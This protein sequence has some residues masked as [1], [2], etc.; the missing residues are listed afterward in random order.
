ML[1]ID[2][3][4]ERKSELEDI[5][6]DIDEQYT[7]DEQADAQEEL[8]EI[9]NFESELGISLTIASQNGVTFIAEHDFTEYAEELASDI[10]AVGVNSYEWP[11]NHIDWDSAAEELK[12]DYSEVDW[13]G[14]AYLFRY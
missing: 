9:E 4:L 2:E 12:M 7:V 8:D 1:D 6:N 14:T 11:I 5:L 3:V 13:Q 10:G